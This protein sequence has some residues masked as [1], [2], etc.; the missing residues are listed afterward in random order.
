M[1]TLSVDIL[2]TDSDLPDKIV[3]ASGEDRESW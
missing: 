3:F 1:T 2:T